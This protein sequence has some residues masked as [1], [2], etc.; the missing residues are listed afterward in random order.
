M[1]SRYKRFDRIKRE[2]TKAEN[3]ATASWQVYFKIAEQLASVNDIE[4]YLQ[5]RQKA[6]QL[7][8]AEDNKQLTKRY[9]NPDKASK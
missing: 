8:E 5:N 1:E 3:S 4:G 7:L 9:H 2:K 6:I